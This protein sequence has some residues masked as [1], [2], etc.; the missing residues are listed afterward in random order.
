M[1]RAGMVRPISAP[2]MSCAT[3][4]TTISE[5]AVEMRSQI[6]MRL[7][8]RASDSH[9]A[10]SAQTPVTTEPVAGGRKGRVARGFGFLEIA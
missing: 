8:T 7:A 5:S 4:P 1:S 9:S 2:V 3:V 6:E 10:A